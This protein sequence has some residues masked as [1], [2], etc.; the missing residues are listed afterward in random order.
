MGRENVGELFAHSI[1]R[2]PPFDSSRWNP[3]EIPP[4]EEKKSIG[5]FETK[6]KA[7]EALLEK[8]PSFI[9][10]SR[11]GWFVEQKYTYDHEPLFI[12]SSSEFIDEKKFPKVVK[13]QRRG[14]YL[15]PHPIHRLVRKLIKVSVII[16]LILM[17]LYFMSM[18]HD[19]H[20]TQKE[21]S[22][23][24][25]CFHRCIFTPCGSIV[26]AIFPV[27]RKIG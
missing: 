15:H 24:F 3:E 27:V 9:I 4:A 25:S 5:F 22:T 13:Q 19:S 17:P 11:N 12:Q 21:P 16:L 26:E 2:Y 1:I 18:V 10:G 6:E 7:M 20:W 14:W 23:R 8:M